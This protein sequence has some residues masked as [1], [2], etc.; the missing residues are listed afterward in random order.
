[1]IS[2]ARIHLMFRVQVWVYRNTVLAM[3][4]FSSVRKIMDDP[5]YDGWFLHFKNGTDGKGPLEHDGQLNDPHRDTTYHEPVGDCGVQYNARGACSIAPIAKNTS[6]C[7][8][9]IR[10]VLWG[11]MTGAPTMRSAPPPSPPEGP[12]SPCTSTMPVL[13]IVGLRSRLHSAEVQQ[14]LPRA[15]PDHGDQSMARQIRLSS[16]PRLAPFPW[17]VDDYC[18]LDSCC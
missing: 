15:G 2:C 18:R 3:P 17:H 10:L 16:I 11:I 1:M 12:G 8:G 9:K 7:L 6:T 14:A 13:N 4:W 5:S